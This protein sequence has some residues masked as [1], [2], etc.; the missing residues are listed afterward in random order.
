MKREGGLANNQLAPSS[1]CSS[2]GCLSVTPSSGRLTGPLLLHNLSEEPEASV[3]PA[4]TR[5]RWANIWARGRAEEAPD[6][7]F[8][9]DGNTLIGWMDKGLWLGLPTRPSTPQP[10]WRGTPRL[11]SQTWSSTEAQ[12]IPRARV[13]LSTM[14]ACCWA[15]QHPSP[16]FLAN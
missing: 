7:P 9:F 6:T 13:Q 4:E 8:S 5:R 16:S 15:I 14:A 3:S 12:N 11:E 1:C 2:H 10:S